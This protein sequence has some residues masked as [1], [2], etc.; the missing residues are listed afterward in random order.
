MKDVL[1]RFFRR[2]QLSLLLLLLFASQA[3]A[4]RAA[5][6]LADAVEKQDHTRIQSLLK[7][8]AEVNAAQ[9]DGMTAMLWAA[10]NDDLATAKRLV[11]AHAD[12]NLANRYGVKPLSLACTNGN[13]DLVELL[14]QGGADPNT[15]LPG[16]ETVLM[17]AAR[18]GRVGP[19]K[20][21]LARKAVVDARERGGQTALMWAAAEGHS[22]VVQLLIQAGADFRTPLPSGFTPL[23]FA[24]REGRREVVQRLLKAGA[25]VKEAMQPKRPG[26]KD[27]RK[28]TDALMLAVENGHFE[29]A[30]D[31]L[32]AGADPNDQ[33]SGYTPLHAITWVRRTKTG[34]DP[35]GDPP[36]VGSG[37]M[38][39]LQF[40][41]ELVAH[42]AD[43]NA[44]LQHGPSGRGRLNETGATAF[45]FAAHTADV[46]LMRLLV[47]LGA[48]SK[49]PN[50]DNCPALLAAAG[51]GVMA[52]GEEPGTDEEVVEALKYL[53]QLGADINAVDNNGE[54]AMHGAAYRNA[55]GV[56]SFLADKGADIQTWNRANH[57]SWTPLRIAEGYRV[58]NFKPAPETLAALRRILDAKGV[59][60]SQHAPTKT[61]REEYK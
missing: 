47:E 59:K 20:A 16:G 45:L 51:I 7:Q 25:D 41:R 17:T 50:A 52:P 18:T 27:P 19:V 35:D 9:V 54:T 4:D 15:T 53:L 26:G 8:G 44:R 32:K 6:P 57:Y 58:G 56:V 5:S 30:V 61:T 29:L 23:F 24:V 39:S 2:T 48:D 3:S 46:P 55:P 43:V 40:V 12:T 11:T 31:L 34:D 49:I 33:R 42:G 10:Y 21:L 22:E 13:T 37:T 14:L 28:G 1:T 60:P 36:P 38:S